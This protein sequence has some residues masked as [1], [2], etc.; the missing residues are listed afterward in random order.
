ML[1][2][3]DY[4]RAEIHMKV[5]TATTKPLNT[6]ASS[7]ESDTRTALSFICLIDSLLE[8]LQNIT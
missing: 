1:R 8:T 6:R 7:Y 3:V 4:V 2:A 5:V